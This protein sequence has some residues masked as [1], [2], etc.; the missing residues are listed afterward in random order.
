VVPPLLSGLPPIGITLGGAAA[1]G[2]TSNGGA[3]AT[4]PNPN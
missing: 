2:P 4:D 1:T 3:P